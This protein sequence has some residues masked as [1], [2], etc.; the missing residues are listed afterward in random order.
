MIYQ[1]MSSTTWW[2]KKSAPLPGRDR[3]EN[4]VSISDFVGCSRAMSFFCFF[5][6]LLLSSF[7]SRLL[8]IEIHS[9]TE[10]KEKN[11]KRSRKSW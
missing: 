9:H 2:A 10:R 6:L 1:S 11:E 7:Y 5:L 4:M 8:E 3:A